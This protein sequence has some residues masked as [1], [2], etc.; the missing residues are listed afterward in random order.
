MY[1]SMGNKIAPHCVISYLEQMGGKNTQRYKGDD[2]KALYFIGRTGE[3]E[4]TNNTELQWII[5]QTSSNENN[6]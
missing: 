6:T 4:K 5:M 1:Y 3:I 2:E